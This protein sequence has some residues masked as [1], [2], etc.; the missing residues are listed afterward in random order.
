MDNSHLTIRMVAENGDVSLGDFAKQLEL[1]NALLRQIELQH[2]DRHES[3]ICYRVVDLSHNSPAS[4]TIAPYFTHPPIFSPAQ[5]QRVL[6]GTINTIQQQQI[7]PIGVT[8]P[9]LESLKYFTDLL[10]VGKITELI[11]QAKEIKVTVRKEF[12]QIIDRLIGDISYAFGSVSGMLEAVNIHTKQYIF[13][14]YQPGN[15]KISCYF[16]P[17]LLGKVAQAMGQYVTVTG[18]L[19][20]RGLD[21]FPSKIKVEE[22]ETHPTHEQ[23]PT[24]TSLFGVAKEMTDTLS[25]NTFIDNLRA[26]WN[27]E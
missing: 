3:N 23:L 14:L 15:P 7:A 1:L 8:T 18:E 26:E 20:Y 21:Y 9:I 27:Q 24:L 17:E 13:T 16:R 12:A 6:L 2:S 19:S 4:V 22:I 10:R 11:L 5:V 25:S